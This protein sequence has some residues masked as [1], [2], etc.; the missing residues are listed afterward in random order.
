MKE[1]LTIHDKTNIRRPLA[2]EGD[3]SLS[4]LQEDLNPYANQGQLLPRKK[5]ILI[6]DVEF[7]IGSI[8]KLH[9]NKP[10][11]MTGILAQ[12]ALDRGKGHV[13]LYSEV[14]KEVAKEDAIDK[15]VERKLA[16]KLEKMSKPKKV[17]PKVEELETLDGEELKQAIQEEVIDKLEVKPKK[18]KST[19]KKSE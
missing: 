19:K 2:G 13:R 8:V 16:E 7:N 12:K 11:A 5:Y 6:S 17:E 3:H 4:A 18:K 14:Q 9:P 15:I 1:Q 10:R